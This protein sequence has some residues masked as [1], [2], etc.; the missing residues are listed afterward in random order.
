MME[1]HSSYKVTHSSMTTTLFASQTTRSG[2]AETVRREGFEHLAENL[3]SSR[4]RLH[5]SG[6]GGEWEERAV[7]REVAAQSEE[8]YLLEE[9]GIELP[10]RVER[11]QAEVIPNEDTEPPIQAVASLRAGRVQAEP[12]RLPH[13]G[14]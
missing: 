1:R 2:C 4:R 3:G 6:E 5:W 8:E 7:V 10:G 9:R 11:G 12:R 14:D 13:P